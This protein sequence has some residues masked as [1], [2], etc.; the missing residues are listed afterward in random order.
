MSH[1]A[2]R[3]RRAVLPPPE[4]K[5]QKVDRQ[6]IQLILFLMTFV[7]YAYFFGGSFYIQ[8][9]RYDVIQSFVEPGFH[10]FRTF[11]ID[12]FIA[13]G[14]KERLNTESWSIFDGHYYATEAPGAALLG[15]LAYEPLYH[16]EVSQH[17]QPTT[18]KWSVVNA[19][20]INLFVTVFFGALGVVYVFRLLCGE[21]LSEG[22]ATTLSLV[23]AFATINLPYGT[24]LWG[25]VTALSFLVL[26]LFYLFQDTSDRMLALSGLFG[27]LAIVVDY[28][29]IV[30]VTLFLIVGL[31]KHR[32]RIIFFVLGLAFL[33]SGWGLYNNRCFGSPWMWA[34]GVES[35]GQIFDRFSIPSVGRFVDLLIGGFRGLLIHMPI[36]CL[37]PLG[38]ILWCRRRVGDPLL[39][40]CLFAVI[41]FLVLNSSMID[42]HG[43][44]TVAA[45]YQIVSMVFWVLPLKE[46]KYEGTMLCI[47]VTLVFVSVVNM[48]AIAAVSP[49][50]VAGLQ[51]PYYGC[52]LPKYEI[53]R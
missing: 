53:G 33:L 17:I 3:V 50:C 39:W 38:F 10:E 43:G 6:S 27:G 24:Q 19:Y 8:N 7:A 22:R 52:V 21:Q 37:T 29:S 2:S 14:Q 16:L 51:S 41:G 35:F 1:M 11:T 48:V 30:A 15:V 18:L 13:N 44:R 46:I 5:V 45:R 49:L 4:P 28:F 25:H 23:F 26:S 12:R 31:G 40:I 34:P 32:V 42:W 20:L 47:M 36:L 9:A